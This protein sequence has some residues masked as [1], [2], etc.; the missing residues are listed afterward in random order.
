M[1]SFCPLTNEETLKLVGL[2]QNGD[3]I[4]TEKLINGNFPLIKSI[5]KVYLGKGIEYDD[6]YQIGCVG[7]LKAIKNFNS[8][9]DVKF[10]TYAVPMISGEIKRHLR[11]DGMMKISRSIK[12]LAIKIK[13]FI[14]EYK[15]KHNDSPQ[16]DEI[17]KA[18]GAANEDI[19]IAMDSCQQLIS[20]EA[21]VDENDEGSRSVMDKV[22]IDN[23]DDMIDRFVLKNEINK[24][25]QKKRQIILLR[26]YRG[27]TQSE[28][29]VML[30][31]S[32][33]QVSRIEAK[34]IEQLKSKLII[35]QK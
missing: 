15:S 28:I 30:G 20:L 31:I 3:S 21:K 12:C 19:I 25:S 22:I 33:V 7:F 32:Q 23:S 9:F 13:A 17:S 29:A 27:K 14:E 24:L 18:L 35:E 10:T 1:S 16:I 34:I 26:Y 8:E 5:V 2:S 4:A 6:L 11:D